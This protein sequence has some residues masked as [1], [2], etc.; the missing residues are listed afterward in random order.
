MIPL[1]LYLD[2]M[3]PVDL[4]LILR[5]Y[6]YNVL[7][8]KDAGMLGK[9]DFEQLE[10]SVSEYRAILTFNIGDF[11]RLHNHWLSQ[12]IKHKGIIVSPEVKLSVLIKLCLRLLAVTSNGEINGQLRY[13]QEFQ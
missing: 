13:L 9:S 8:A 1:K 11:M 10:F 2:E 6:G 12:N 4:T 3:I 5:Q 7:T